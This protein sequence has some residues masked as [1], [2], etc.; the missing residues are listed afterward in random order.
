MARG[1][2]EGLPAPSARRS[3]RW[4]LPAAYEDQGW[5]ADIAD[6]RLPL[7]LLLLSGAALGCVF[8]VYLEQ[9]H[10][11]VFASWEDE[12]VDGASTLGG[13]AVLLTL[14]F[15]GL[16]IWTGLWTASENT[17]RVRLIAR[18][19]VGGSVLVVAALVALSIA[20]S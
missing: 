3:G 14:V 1:H 13:P 4:S 7:I 6:A 15:A 19:C 16:G 17:H 20:A 11:T 2:V 5:L 10:L 9:R 8:A 18:G 12:L